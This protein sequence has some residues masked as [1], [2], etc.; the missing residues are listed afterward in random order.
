MPFKA[1]YR[2]LMPSVCCVP[3][4]DVRLSFSTFAQ[5]LIDGRQVLCPRRVKLRQLFYYHVTATQLQCA[6]ILLSVCT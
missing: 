6:R 1:A 5:D 2:C 4:S 3:T